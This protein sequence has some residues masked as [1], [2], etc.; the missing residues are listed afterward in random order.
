M[1]QSIRG[2]ADAAIAL[3][4]TSGPSSVAT[5]ASELSAMSDVIY[6]SDDLEHALSD[7]GVA[8]ESRRA[9][10]EEL[11]GSRVGP[12]TLGLVGF[13][14]VNDRAVD[15]LA[16]VAWLAERV[17]AAAGGMEPVGDVVL[18]TKSA[19]ERADGFATAVLA[20]VEGDRALGEIEDELFR[21]S[22]IVAGHDELNEVLTS[23]DHPPATRRGVVHD[24]LA[25]K[26]SPATVLLAG[27]AASI[28]RPRD[29]LVLL[30][31]LVERVAAETNRR[32]AEVRSAVELDQ[33][34]RERLALVLGRTVGRH[35]DVRVTVDPS[36]VAGF[37]AT[38][39]DTVVDASAHH[40]LEV[41]K[42]RLAMPDVHITTGD[43]H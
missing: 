23:R 42:E 18:A 14:L 20:T 21:F 12:S 16:D 29:Y 31:R 40:Q 32:V 17:G 15:F 19:E 27:Y 24:L 4:G 6:G 13:V 5:M 22:R 7:P 8:V 34:Q 39:G 11:F 3:A 33:S 41:L 35:V 26:A 25:G 2:Y 1:R 38:I 36:V 43:G 37:V 10:L 30:E 28:G 9:V